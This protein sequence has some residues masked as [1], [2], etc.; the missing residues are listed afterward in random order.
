MP[1]AFALADVV[2]MA[3]VIVVV[4]VVVAVVVFLVVMVV[5]SVF[6]HMLAAR[7]SQMGNGVHATC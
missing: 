7:S 1:A 6:V 5:A 4:V 3:T 2:V